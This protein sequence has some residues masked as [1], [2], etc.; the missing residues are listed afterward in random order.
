MVE[1]AATALRSALCDCL[2][3]SASY[4]MP[5]SFASQTFRLYAVSIT[6]KNYST[7][8]GAFLVEI[9]ATALRS[10]LCDC[11]VRSASYFMPKSFA[12]Q[13][14]RLYAV[15]ITAKKNKAPFRVLLLV[16]MAA[17]ALRSALCACLVRSASYFMRKALLRKLF[18]WMRFRLPLKNQS[19][20][21]GAFLVEMAVIETAS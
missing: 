8:S 1:I 17:T 4:F 10:A 6:V 12:S 11:L 18:D 20:L 7:L 3:R 21:S 9:A 15:S 5:K 14:F 2:V 19:T 16:E 13:T